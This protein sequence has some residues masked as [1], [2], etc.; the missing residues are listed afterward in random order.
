METTASI[1]I[2]RP[3]AEVF[4]FIADMANNTAWQ[5]G[6][7]S[8]VWTSSPPHG[9]GSTYDQVAKFLG[10]TITSSFE[11]TEFE[12]GHK[13]RIETTSG[14]MPI[15][16]TRT[17]IDRDGVSEVTALVTGTPPL[18]MRSLGPV[19]RWIVGASVRKDYKRLKALLES[20]S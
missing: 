16:V 9:V 10:M 15:D 3:A 14:T 18:V 2:D 11:V 1:T 12:D 8:C 7:Q 6:Q 19:N 5:N 4:A 13:I 20:G 17:V